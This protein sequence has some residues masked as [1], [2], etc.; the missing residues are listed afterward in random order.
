MKHLTFEKKQELLKRM[1]FLNRLNAW[2]A[3]VIVVLCI[4]LLINAISA[5]ETTNKWISIIAVVNLIV[6]F[7]NCL[8][9]VFLEKKG[10]Y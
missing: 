5:P 6:T 8:S 3:S 7:V 4:L 10:Y 2:I 1:H 9:L